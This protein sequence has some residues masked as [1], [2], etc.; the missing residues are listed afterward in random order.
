VTDAVLIQETDRGRVCMCPPGQ[1][2]SVGCAEGVDFQLRNAPVADRH[3]DL[4]AEADGS[5]SVVPTSAEGVWINGQ[6][7]HSRGSARAGD[8][9]RLGRETEL[10]VLGILRADAPRRIKGLLQVPQLLE[11]HYI[12]LRMVGRGA[13]GLVYEAFDRKENRRVAIKVMLAG[14]RASPQVVQRFQREA[15]LQATLGDYP[16]IV[17][18]Y[19]LGTVPD[20]GELFCVMEY[21]D[22]ITLQDQIAAGLP[23]MSGVRIAARVARAVA[24]AHEHGLVHRD[25]KPANVMVSARGVIRLTDFGVCKALAE[26]AGV[27]ATGVMLGTPCY[28]AP[29]QI[30]DAKRVGPEADIYALGILLYVVITGQKPFRGSSLRVILQAVEAGTFSEP[31]AIDPSIDPEVEAICLKAMHQVPMERQASALEFAQELEAYLR[32]ADPPKK[33]KLRLPKS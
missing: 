21:V 23:R 11:P 19:A 26:D 18:V 7:V 6:E 31:S 5:L 22:G 30:A 14:G 29:E 3:C 16:G 20:S 9:V 1:P 2:I 27:T 12:L 33:V 25:L 24:Y 10:H 4:R 8:R 15:R 32:G 28:M 13:A 17:S